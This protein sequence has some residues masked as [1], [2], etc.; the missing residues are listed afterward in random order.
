MLVFGKFIRNFKVRV[1]NIYCD[2]YSLMEG[3]PQGSMLSITL[4]SLK[5]N[6][7]LSCL[8]PDIKYS[9]YVDDLAIYYSSRHLPYIERKLHQS[10]NIL[11]RCFSPIKRCVSIFVNC[12]NNIYILNSI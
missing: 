11:S 9:L 8:L 10:L 5:I 12:G 4:F 7:I 1:W 6:S 3:V 2:S